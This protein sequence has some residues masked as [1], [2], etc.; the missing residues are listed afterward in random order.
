MPQSPPPNPVLTH[1]FCVFQP[2]VSSNEMLDAGKLHL[3]CTSCVCLA[4]FTWQQ[5]SKDLKWLPNIQE[6]GEADGANSDKRDLWSSEHLN[7]QLNWFVHIFKFYEKS[8]YYIGLTEINISMVKFVQ[9]YKWHLNC[10]TIANS[11]KVLHTSLYWTIC[12]WIWNS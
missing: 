4:A 12:S 7:I 10:I 11:I 8:T 2:D 5:V 3:Y 1:F 9:G 6:M